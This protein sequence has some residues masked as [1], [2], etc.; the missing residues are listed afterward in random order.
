MSH[1]LLNSVETK[2][3]R[4]TLKK[5]LLIERQVTIFLI[6]DLLLTVTTI[7]KTVIGA[8]ILSFP[9][10]F[11][12]LGYIFGFL[13]FFVI[14]VLTQFTCNILMRSKNLSRHSNFSTI[15]YYV[16]PNRII[17]LLPSIAIFSANFGVCII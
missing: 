15:I 17:Q 16:F 4:R 13:M 6:K 1:T 5:M 11:S 8:G 7:I 9:F 12:R 10:T 14:I 3:L 2:T